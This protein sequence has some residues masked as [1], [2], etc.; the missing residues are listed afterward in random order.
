MQQYITRRLLLAVVTL[1]GVSWLIF[2]L[3]WIIPGR[4]GCIGRICSDS[5]PLQT[6][7]A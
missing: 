2:F 7:S 5:L 4:V 6:S 1:V 3:M